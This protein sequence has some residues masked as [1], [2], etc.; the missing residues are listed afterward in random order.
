[1]VDEAEF[2]LHHR[3]YIGNFD[4]TSDWSK[5]DKHFSKKFEHEQNNLNSGVVGG[6]KNYSFSL[7]RSNDHLKLQKNSA[8]L[9]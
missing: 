3:P 2:T 9:P 6:K 4:L 8:E 7:S 1:M 5:N